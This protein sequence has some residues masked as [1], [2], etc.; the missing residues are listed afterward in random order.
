M[1]YAYILKSKNHGR[2]YIGS[3][4]NLIDRLRRHN[5]GLNK[6]TRTGVPWEMIYSETFDTRQAAY[7]RELKIKSYKGGEAFK[8]LIK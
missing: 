7:N 8:R 2:Y 1:F 5:A 4:N 3:T 6:S